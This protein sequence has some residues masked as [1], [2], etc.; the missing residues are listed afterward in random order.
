MAKERPRSQEQEQEQRRRRPRGVP[1]ALAFT[2]I[3]LALI[4]GGGLG[5]L[6]GGGNDNTSSIEYETQIANA[7]QRIEELEGMLMENGIDPNAD[8]FDGAQSLDPSVVSALDGGG[9]GGAWAAPAASACAAPVPANAAVLCPY[10][11]LLP[12]MHRYTASV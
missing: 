4:V 1:K 3:A 10:R 7:N 5:F 8:V 9:D 6:L 2:L 11:F 12:L